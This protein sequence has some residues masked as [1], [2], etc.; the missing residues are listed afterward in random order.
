[1]DKTELEWSHVKR[2]LPSVR[3]S[4]KTVIEQSWRSSPLIL[5]F[6]IRTEGH[7]MQ[8]MNY[9]CAPLRQYI[10][11]LEGCAVEYGKFLYHRYTLF[12]QIIQI[13]FLAIS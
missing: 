10:F 1:M 4:D 7:K 3:L 8:H 5:V 13:I 9:D 11:R 12:I 2:H 6:A